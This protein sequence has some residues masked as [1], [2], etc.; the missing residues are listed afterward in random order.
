MVGGGCYTEYN[1]LRVYAARKAANSAVAKRIVYGATQLVS[2]N[3]FI[4]QVSK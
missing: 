1:N 2:P 4:I 3:D